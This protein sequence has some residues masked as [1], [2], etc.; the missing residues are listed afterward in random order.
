[1]VVVRQ[2]LKRPHRLRGPEVDAPQD[3][4]RFD[5]RFDIRLERRLSVEL[6]GEV[7]HVATLHQAERRRIRPSTR[8]VDAHGRPSP[9]DLVAL[10]RHLRML[11]VGRGL[12]RQSLPQ[13]REGAV[14][15]L[16]AT[17][18]TPVLHLRAEHRIVDAAHQV[19]MLGQRIGQ[20]QLAL[21][22]VVGSVEQVD[23][24]EDAVGIV[25][26]QHWPVFRPET[27]ALL[28][29]SLQVRLVGD[30]LRAQL[31]S[32]L[33]GLLRF[34]RRLLAQQEAQ[35]QARLLRRVSD[36]KLLLLL[37]RPCKSVVIAVG[38]HHPVRFADRHHIHTLPLVQPDLPVVLGHTRDDVLARQGPALAYPAVLHPEV[39]VLR[40]DAH[41]RD[42]ILYEH[43]RMR[44]QRVVH[45]LPLVVDEI[46][47]RQGRG[48]EFV[49]RAKMV[50]FATR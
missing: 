29:E 27:A 49:G 32:R 10:H 46:L 13:Q 22:K 28:R 31:P 43:C 8:Y 36:G 9:Y 45:D 18:S 16:L 37:F 6:Y 35:Q 21:H 17:L 7:D 42:G 50:K 5:A 33:I 44:L 14:G 39:L 3:D 20:R 23:L 41:P 4:M 34:L 19:R 24:I 25:A 48:E 40:R 1:M 30:L 2:L 26:R 12:R 38:A 15:V 47:D 11:L